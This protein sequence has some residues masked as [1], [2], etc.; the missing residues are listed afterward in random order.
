[1]DTLHHNPKL[2]K[3]IR[4]KE[5][6]KK[7]LAFAKN[8]IIDKSQHLIAHA[9]RNQSLDHINY[10]IH[11]LLHNPYTFIN[12][13]AAISKNKGALTKGVKEDKQINLFFGQTN[14]NEIA[15]KFKKD[16]YRFRPVRRTWIDKPGKKS[17]RPIDTPTQEDRVV[18]EAIRGIL[19]SIYEPVFRDFGE[20]TN[21]LADNFGFRPKLSTWHAV[22]RIKMFG[23][24]TTFAIEGDI[25]KAYNTINHNV[26]IS[27]LSIRIK[28]KKFLIMIRNLLESGI[29]DDHK[30]EHSLEGTPQGGI[31]SPLLFNIYMFEFDKYVYNN[32]IL[33]GTAYEPKPQKNLEWQNLG[34]TIRTNLK[35]WQT[36]SKDDIAKEKYYKPYK[37]AQLKRLTIPSYK[38]ETI[39]KRKL[40]VRYAD[41]W[42][43]LL[44]G[45]HEEA[46]AIKSQIQTYL[47]Q[48]LH[49]ELS[50]EKTL[51]TKLQDGINFLGFRIIMT[52]PEQTKITR[53]RTAPKS[54]TDYRKALQR[55]TSRKIHI[56][57]DH[58][59]LHTRL[60][61]RK[62]ATEDLFPI[63]VLS[64]N[65]FDEYEI[66]LKYSRIMV[67]LANYYRNCDNVYTLNRIS[68][69][70]QYSC[71]KTIA[72]RQK[73]SMPQVFK[74]YG[75][76]LTIERTFISKGN[77]ITRNVSFPTLNDLR[78]KGR[79]TYS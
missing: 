66:V 53:V 6:K 77:K 69:I 3:V 14:A 35:K 60:T 30:F 38:I 78:K 20:V 49:L 32:I 43:L 44:T 4:S 70:L 51:I 79:L 24:A 54:K 67:G 16:T 37:A 34:Y 73:V 74:K 7:F 63:G 15:N 72:S 21:K 56:Y 1:M 29:M 26:L 11:H 57:P 5:N 2:T 59:R 41:D 28:D 48:S 31:V 52:R 68:Y 64:W 45:T 62:F 55:T 46:Q 71:A 39:P 36:S 22:N 17:K 23:Q 10:K 13:Y 58:K 75:K 65:S 76:N 8:E 12:A 9:K 50:K 47:K 61:Q 33:P 18:Q 42:V 40:F 27:I 19:E 25:S